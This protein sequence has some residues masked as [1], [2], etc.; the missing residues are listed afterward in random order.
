MDEE[1]Q[2]NLIA[3][4]GVPVAQPATLPNEKPKRFFDIPKE[5]VSIVA[6][7]MNVVLKMSPNTK[8]QDIDVQSIVDNAQAMFRDGVKFNDKFWFQHTAAS[9]R[10]LI[11]FTKIESED[12]HT[13]HSSIPLYSTDQG[14][15]ERLDKIIAIRSYLSDIVHFVP[16]NRL[17]IMHK[18]YPTDGYGT[19]DKDKFF[20]DEEA[21]FEKVCIDLVYIL[22]DLFVK[23]CVGKVS[24]PTPNV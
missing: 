10:E 18:L 14:V 4:E 20:K 5:V 24:A 9:I 2:D 7:Y 13:A 19:M 15:K 3:D 16:G 12:F 1:L 23:Y 22:N 6:V 8:H 21:H 11:G 17:G